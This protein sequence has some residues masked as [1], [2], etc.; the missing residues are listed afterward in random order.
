MDPRR[1]VTPLIADKWEEAIHRAGMQDSSSDVPHGLRAGFRLGTSSVLD[2]TVVH[3]NHL[4]AVKNPSAIEN[5]IQAELAAGRYSGLFTRSDLQ[6]RIGHFRASPLGVV[7]KPSAPGS[8]HVIQ[9]FSFPLHDDHGIT[10][11]NSEIDPEQFTCLWGF[12]SDVVAIVLALP[13]GSQAATFDVDAAYQRMPVHPLDQPHIVV[14]WDGRFYVDHCVPFGA[15]SSNGIF[16]R[17]S[18]CIL[19][20]FCVHS[21]PHV[22]KWVDDFCFLRSP[23]DSAATI[24]SFEYDESLIYA[25]AEALGWPWKRTKTRPFANIFVY[26]GFE[27]SITDRSAAIPTAKKDKFLAKIKAWLAAPKVSLKAT[28]S[29]LGS[30]IHCALAVP[31][32]RS[33][34]VGLSRFLAGFSCDYKRCY[35]TRT[36][37]AR[38][39]EDT[40]WWRDQLSASWCGSILKPPPPLIPRNFYMDASTSFGIGIVSKREYGMLYLK[41]NWASNGRDIGWAKIVAVEITLDVIISAGITNTSIRFWSDNQGIIGAIRAGRSRNDEQNLVLRRIE[42][43]QLVHNIWLESGYVHTEE[44]LA[45][46]PSRGIPPADARPFPGPV[47][48]SSDLQPF[49][50]PVE[51]HSPSPCIFTT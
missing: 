3:R 19:G 40:I 17:C 30:L 45:D 37:T 48:L 21:I 39:L 11:V 23:T 1:V 8:L 47:V 32:G 35:V 4:S 5:H 10:S 41:N 51:A 15:A 7:D 25:V 20:I 26:L 43:K 28:E 6:A 14:H 33:R 50:S 36:R 34:I 31:A 18:D 42:E 46:E 9:D 16:G 12:F 29:L 49:V 22:I 27:W 13:P 2:S 44:N 24:A 38:A